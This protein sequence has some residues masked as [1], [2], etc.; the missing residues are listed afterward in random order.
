M[1]ILVISLLVERKSLNLKLTIKKFN[2]PA[3]LCLGSIYN[4]FSAHKSKEVTLNGNVCDFLAIYSS[5][6]KSDKL[7]IQKYLMTKNNIK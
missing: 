2:F 7:N 3:Q 5:S 1:L 6:D 4:G